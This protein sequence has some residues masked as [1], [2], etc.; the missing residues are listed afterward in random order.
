MDR[1]RILYCVRTIE[2][3]TAVKKNEL[4]HASAQRTHRYEAKE[5]S[6]R[7]HNII[8]NSKPTRVNYIV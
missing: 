2:Y 6:C 1:E 8:T 4:H 7:I 5:A 3:Y